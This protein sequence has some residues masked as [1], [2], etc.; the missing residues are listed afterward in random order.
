MTEEL[1]YRGGSWL[2][3]RPSEKRLDP[4]SGLILPTHGVSV[5]NVP[6]NLDRFGGAYQLSKIP[7]KLRIIQRGGNPNHF[8]VVPAYPMSL[9]EYEEALDQISLV[10]I[11]TAY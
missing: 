7:D 2:R 9:V 3:P 5:F 8:E 4:V 6:D 11:G 1:Y 10:R